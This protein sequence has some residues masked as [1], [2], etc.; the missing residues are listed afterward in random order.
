MQKFDFVE[1]GTNWPRGKSGKINVTKLDRL[2][3]GCLTENATTA[4]QA[5][6]QAAQNVPNA[7]WR[8]LWS[9]AARH[10][11]LKLAMPDEFGGLGASA[12]QCVKTMMAFGREVTDNGLTL[13]L[14]SHIWTVQQ[15]L[16]TFGT[17]AQKSNYLSDLMSGQKI[18]AYALTEEHSGSD[19]MALQTSAKKVDGGYIL[20]GAKTFVGMGPCFDI[21]LVFASTAPERKAWGVSVFVVHKDDKGISHGPAQSKLGLKTLPM[22][23][24][25]FNNCFIL[26]TR[27]LGPEGAGAQIF[28]TTL[29]WERA[30]I[31][32]SHVGAMT[33]QVEDCAHFA[34]TRETF[35]KPILEHQSVSN[36]LADMALRA[37][38]ARLILLSA[39]E[40]YD[41]GSLSPEMAAMTNLHISEGFLASSLDAVRNF[42]GKG[43]LDG[44]QA[45]ADFTD[46]LGGV[47]YSGTSDV[48]RQI[49]ARM[50]AQRQGDHQ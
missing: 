25:E 1:E 17:D 3:T 50:T 11:L 9:I 38:T 27:R 18:G 23:P 37:E 29:D 47:I 48:Q 32:S 20:N 4:G 31:L 42:G 36:R 8:T 12:S 39:A 46:A 22:G 40:R 16:I 43:Y 33:R 13:G 14:N 34:K 35:G 26:E 15:P 19:A 30:F 2:S 28:Q 44:S 5:I 49:I 7:D 21:A 45:G 24:V 6:L 41:A 10:G